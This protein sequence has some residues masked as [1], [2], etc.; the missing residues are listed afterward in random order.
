M[1]GGPVLDL[2]TM[3]ETVAAFVASAGAIVFM[4]GWRRSRRD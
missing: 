4:V 3:P 1:K 2:L